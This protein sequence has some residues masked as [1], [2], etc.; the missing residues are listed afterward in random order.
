LREPIIKIL[1][2]VVIFSYIQAL[3]IGHVT[4]QIKGKIID[5]SNRSPLPGASIMLDDSSFTTSDQQGVF[6]FNQK[7]FPITIMASY[8]GY[9]P[10]KRQLVKENEKLIIELKASNYMLGEVIITAYEGTQKIIESPGSVA[11]IPQKEMK[12][13]NDI[14]FIPSLNRV[15]GIYAHSGT[16]NTNRITIRGIGSRSLFITSKIRAYYDNIP[17]TT[18]DGE[19]TVEDIDPNLIDRLETIKGPSSSLYGAGLGGTILIQS[20]SASNQD[21]YVKYELTGGSYGYLK[22]D[23]SIAYGNNKNRLGV[24]INKIRSDGYRENNNYDRFTSG[25]NFISFLSEKSKL[26]FLSTYIKLDAQIPSSIDRLTYETNPRAAASNWAE[27]E[28][29]EDNRKIISGLGFNHVFN[30]HSSLDISIFHTY[31]DSYERRPFNILNDKNNSLGSRLKYEYQNCWNNYRFNFIAG[32]EYFIDFYT[33][34]TYENDDKEKGDLLSDN[35]ETREN[36][37]VFLKADLTFPFKTYLT[38]GVNLNRT[39]YNYQSIYAQDGSDNS[40]DYSFGTILS[41]RIALSHPVTSRIYVYGTIS[42]GFSPPSVPETLTPSG[43]I[44]PDIRPETGINYEIGS[45]GMIIRNKLFYDINLFT[46]HIN[47]LIVAQRIDEDEFIGINAGKTVNNGLE[48]T[49]NYNFLPDNAVNKELTGFITYTLADYNFKEFVEAGNDYSGNELTGIP[50]NVFNAGIAFKIPV[51]LYGNLNYQFVDEMPMRDDNSVYSDPYQLM[52]LKLGYSRSISNHFEIDCNGILN[53]IF[54][55]KYASMISVNAA[56]F[57]G[58]LP[59][60]YYPGLPTNFFLGVGIT[61]NF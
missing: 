60:Y 13:D 15:T 3:I 58:N 8:I 46:M 53:N 55:E 36:L 20:K 7:S 23:L 39:Y 59:R 50:G 12:I 35:K 32:G 61:Y 21:K 40:G 57:G 27:T 14:Y 16:Y 43:T 18:G 1:K 26:R 30:D 54:N 25:I 42:H 19:T 9:E 2:L 22:N 51:G 31:R 11:L 29:F 45:K 44:N 10:Y 38:I 28:G 47:D 52:N 33:W 24:V 56:S 34:Q 37:N 48:V 5:A 49:L 17:L 6:H 41:P 4:G